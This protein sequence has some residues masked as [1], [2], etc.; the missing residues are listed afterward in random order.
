MYSHKCIASFP[1]FALRNAN[2]NYVYDEIQPGKEAKF[3]EFRG[4][5]AV[6][7]RFL[8]EIWE[9]SI[10]GVVKANNPREFSS[11]KSYFSSLR[12]SFLPQKFPLYGIASSS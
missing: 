5:V 9:R 6:R 7:E 12:E 11:R 10:F 4:F 1:G 8:R 3:R 2:N